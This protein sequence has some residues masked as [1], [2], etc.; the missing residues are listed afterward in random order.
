[1]ATRFRFLALDRMQTR[2]PGGAS[3]SQPAQY[4][5]EPLSDTISE[6]GM[7]SAGHGG[8]PYRYVYAATAKPGWFLFDGLVRHDVQTG[9]EQ[10]ITFGEG[11]AAAKP[12]W[13]SCR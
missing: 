5:K 4:A 6:F 1:M 11:S 3:T 12:R 2:L 10:R 7:I 9:T 13:P 8:E